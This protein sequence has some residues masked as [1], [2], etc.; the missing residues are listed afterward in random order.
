MGIQ[1]FFYP[2]NLFD[3]GQGS[4]LLFENLDPDDIAA[5]V[6]DPAFFLMHFVE[7]DNVVILAVQFYVKLDFFP[8]LRLRASAFILEAFMDLVRRFVAYHAIDERKLFDLLP[9]LVVHGNNK[10]K[11]RQIISYPAAQGDQLFLIRFLYRPGKLNDPFFVP[12]P[13]AGSSSA[14]TEGSPPLTSMV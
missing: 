14:G 5:H 8:L 9:G 6:M 3:A 10:G 2:Q 7:H 11:I 1:R 12:P 13:S 4:D